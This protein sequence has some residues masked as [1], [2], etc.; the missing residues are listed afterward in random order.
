MKLFTYSHRRTPL[1]KSWC[2]RSVYPSLL[3]HPLLHF[4][5]INMATLDFVWKKAQSQFLLHTLQWVPAASAVE[6]WRWQT[7]KKKRFKE[8]V[9]AMEF[10]LHPALF[11]L[12]PHNFERS[13]Y[14]HNID[15][16]QALLEL[17]QQHPTLDQILSKDSRS[18]PH[19]PP[20]PPHPQAPVQLSRQ[21][22][23][24]QWPLFLPHGNGMHYVRISLWIMCSKMPPAC[25]CYWKPTHDE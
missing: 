18:I 20:P 7:D 24:E 3:F 2:F 13:V 19:Y 25:P 9:F 6:P 17:M 8:G 23:A 22:H 5:C 4:T 21:D 1:L 14:Q 12:R 10:H 16:P 15:S 11:S